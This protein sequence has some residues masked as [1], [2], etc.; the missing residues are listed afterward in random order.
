M[1]RYK[2]YLF[3]A[4]SGILLLGFL[5]N[6]VWPGAP[7][8]G[9]RIDF[10]NTATVKHETIVV[11]DL[12]SVQ[13]ENT[14]KKKIEK[15]RIFPSPEPGKEKVL[16]GKRI[17][18]I[19]RSTKWVP[20][21]VRINIPEFIWVKRAFQTIPDTTLKDLLCRY[22]E[23]HI[24]DAEYR[25]HNFKAHGKKEYITGKMKLVVRDPSYNGMISGIIKLRVDVMVDGKVQGKIKLYGRVDRFEYAICASRFIQKGTVLNETNLEKKLTNISKAPKNIVK[26]L[27]KALNK[28]LKYSLRPGEFLR[29]NMLEHPVVIKRGELIKLIAR[30]GLLTVVAY[31]TAQND[32]AIGEQIKVENSDTNRTVVGRVLNESSVLVLF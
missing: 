21:N 7:T 3:L 14:V 13:A 10:S 4:L 8:T 20:K 25:L 30:S 11:G 28:C 6:R 16:N 23:R 9:V 2:T 27:D 1:Q 12:A 15:I 26:H 29:Q 18:S 17:A 22:I 32:G 5:P 19:I 24:G 31:G